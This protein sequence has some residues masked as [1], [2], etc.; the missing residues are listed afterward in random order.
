MDN[1]VKVDLPTT[2]IPTLSGKPVL[3]WGWGTRP[4]MEEAFIPL[5]SPRIPPLTLAAGR[6]VSCELVM[7][8]SEGPKAGAGAAQ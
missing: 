1:T 4:Q 5:S 6:G 7:M 8:W 2:M 3:S